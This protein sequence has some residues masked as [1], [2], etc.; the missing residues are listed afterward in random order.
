MPP[1]AAPKLRDYKF[2]PGKNM[3][4]CIIQLWQLI[5]IEYTGVF[6]RISWSGGAKR[7]TSVWQRASSH[8]A[9]TAAGAG[10]LDS[11]LIQLPKPLSNR[12]WNRGASDTPLLS[13][14]GECP[15]RTTE[16]TK[17]RETGPF[18]FFY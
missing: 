7:Q 12:P 2:T 10:I 5:L 6:L 8:L 15:T 17:A 16:M 3:R 11:S 13:N 14:N 18:A 4:M 1:K 9:Q